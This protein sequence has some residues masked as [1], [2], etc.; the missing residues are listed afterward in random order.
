MGGE[1]FGQGRRLGRVGARVQ[2]RRRDQQAERPQRAPVAA[3]RA[4]HRVFGGAADRAQFRT[5]P[6]A[7]FARAA[8][9]GG[10]R[11][12]AGEQCPGRPAQ[13]SVVPAGGPDRQV[14]RVGQA[15]L[16]GQGQL[17]DQRVDGGVRECLVLRAVHGRTGVV[18]VF[19]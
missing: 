11:R 12:E 9:R 18:E 14:A 16:G 10:H 17:A 19:R 6:G 5:E 4:A 2:R 7:G 3:A 13:G 1:V 15:R 8:G